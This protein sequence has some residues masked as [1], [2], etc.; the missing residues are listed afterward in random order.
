[1][2]EP[3][4]ADTGERRPDHDPAE[5]DPA[6]DPS[7]G[8]TDRAGR[9]GR[10]PVVR[11]LQAVVAVLVLAVV[12]TPV[13][14]TMTG[15]RDGTMVNGDEAVAALLPVEFV[16]G[17][18]DLVFPGNTYQGVLEVPAYAAL[19]WIAGPYELPMRLLHQLL[20]IAAVAVWAWLAIDVVGRAR[21]ASDRARWWAALAV[22]GLLG[23]TSVAGWPVWFRIYPGYHL[24][25]LL[26]G[27]AVWV[28]RGPDRTGR[29]IGAGALAG[30]AVYA[31]PMH[32]AGA[33]AVLVAAAAP[34]VV[35]L[36]WWRRIGAAGAGIVVGAAP[37]LL[38]NLR[39]SFASLDSSA[40][41]V[42]HPE[43]GYLD[44]AWNTVR[45][46]GRVLWGDAASPPGSAGGLRFV[47]GAVVLGL[48]VAGVTALARGGRRAWP[49]LSVVVVCLLGLP[50]LRALS[51]DVD[52]RYA[53]GWWPGLVVAV[54][55][56]AVAATSASSPSLRRT[57][58]AALCVGV[59]AHLVVV[60]AGAWTAVRD[61]TRSPSAE[62]A[63]RDLAD[64]LRRCGVDALA[65]DYWAV[66]PA[67]WGSDAALDGGVQF[68]PERLDDVAPASWADAARVAVLPPPNVVDPLDAAALVGERT[69]RRAD[70]W[71]ATVHPG[72]GARVVLEGPERSLPSGCIGETGL[73]RA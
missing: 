18:P 5:A 49:L 71:V 65:G 13:V 2:T 23:A 22:A 45:L 36:P 15:V 25:A 69:G 12:A 27:L 37:L 56:G 51:L 33:V 50:A 21:G 68:G 63:T 67:V 3:V 64:D 24:G 26:A 6:P 8:P 32:A 14:A 17:G 7:G 40:Q 4:P 16:R 1:M 19:W 34:A 9:A 47:A 62:A 11:S 61:R 52:L 58:T 43:W 72:T 53:T 66:Y 35:V 44:R 29:W 10:D 59:A 20:W 39:N 73:V 54:G 55:A 70:G 28:A 60:G 46:T 41:P 42:Q 30:L 57:A 31:Q 38:W 48:G